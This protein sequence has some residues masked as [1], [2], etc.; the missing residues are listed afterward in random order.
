M[1]Y[2]LQAMNIN[3]GKAENYS[4]A[5]EKRLKDDGLLGSKPLESHNQC[6]CERKL[7]NRVCFFCIN[8]NGIHACFGQISKITQRNI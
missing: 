4:Y 3:K 6:G 2:C 7:P 1:G 8:R 5:F